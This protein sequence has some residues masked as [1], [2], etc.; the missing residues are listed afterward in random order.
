MGR[1]VHASA[2][3]HRTIGHG[4][5]GGWDCERRAGGREGRRGYSDQGHPRSYGIEL[6]WE[7]GVLRRQVDLR[8]AVATA[9]RFARCTGKQISDLMPMIAVLWERA[10]ARL[11]VRA[12]PR[13][14]PTHSRTPAAAVVG[15]C[16]STCSSTCSSDSPDDDRNLVWCAVHRACC[17]AHFA[18]RTL[19]SCMSHGARCM[20]CTWVLCSRILRAR[21]TRR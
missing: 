7:D 4:G 18:R 11:Y 5:E 2:E 3:A 10:H 13:V 21:S 12:E 16:S 8:P 9:G 17:T 15:I 19:H 1:S 20:C 14:G 6:R